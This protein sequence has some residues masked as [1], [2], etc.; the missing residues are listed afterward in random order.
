MSDNKRITRSNS[1]KT[2]DNNRPRTQFG[3]GTKSQHP[4]L[5]AINK[6]S[7]DDRR[8][9]FA[10]I[11]HQF[12]TPKDPS[13]SKTTDAILSRIDGAL[14]RNQDLSSQISAILSALSGVHE[15]LAEHN[16]MVSGLRSTLTRVIKENESLRQR[17]SCLEAAN[18]ELQQRSRLCNIELRGIPEKPGEDASALVCKAVS[19]TGFSL[20]LDDVEVAHRI[21]STRRDLPRPI[22]AQLRSRK[23]K[24][25]LMDRVRL[26]RREGH[27]IL[28]SDVVPRVAPDNASDN[29]L[30]VSIREQMSPFY[31]RLFRLAMERAKNNSVE[32]FVWFKDGKLYVRENTPHFRSKVVRGLEDIDRIFGFSDAASDVPLANVNGI[33]EPS[34]TADT[35]A[36]TL[37]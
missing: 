31:R 29:P 20:E 22:I 12:E 16:I 2:F 13:S 25:Q 4:P 7:G 37:A 32:T 9:S 8:L 18:E 33:G 10:D 3:S 23:L 11:K 1:H 24:L 21:P 35:G 15:Q 30:E 28:D 14:E 6:T 27:K 36:S 5:P 34:V 17:I 26:V 19:S